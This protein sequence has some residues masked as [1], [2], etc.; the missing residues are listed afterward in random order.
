MSQNNIKI[1]L[2]TLVLSVVMGCHSSRIHM[3]DIDGHRKTVSE[4]YLYSGSVGEK[5]NSRY[6]ATNHRQSTVST[7]S[8]D[9]DTASYTYIQQCID[10]GKVPSS[11]RIRI[12]EMI[13]YFDYNY[14]SPD[15]EV[16]VSVEM[17]LTDCPWDDNKNLVH[18]GLRARDIKEERKPA[19][20]VFLIDV[21]GSMSSREKLPLLKEGMLAMVDELNRH[22][23]VAIVTYAGGAEL[24]LKSTVCSYSG[25][26]RIMEAIEDLSSGGSTNGEAG[27]HLAYEI[28]DQ[29]FQ[30]EAINRV[31]LASDGDFNV[32]ATSDNK[33]VRLVRQKAQEGVNLTVLGFGNGGFND[34]MMEKISNNGNGNYFYISNRKNAEEILCKKLTSTLQNAAEDVKLQVEFN[35][36]NIEYY[37][38]VGYSNRIMKNSDFDKDRKDAGDM[39]L[40]HTVTALYEVK[41]RNPVRKLKYE[42]T[43]TASRDVSKELLTLSIRYKQPGEERSELLR[44]TLD[45]GELT[46]D[47]DA[48]FATIVA[49]FG[50]I[51][52]GRGDINETEN[53]IE[54]VESYE[55]DD[56]KKKRDFL[57]MMCQYVDILEER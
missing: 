54:T 14:K 37:R 44:Q 25:K 42:S 20:L 21:S 9:V 18:I 31:I 57:E 6:R 24:E 41:L 53:L 51:L 1:T 33:M 15:D 52:Q 48:H 34:S 12:E 13:N 47:K 4:A 45:G 39:G 38:L 16:P 50:L 7:F 36:Q 26:K 43:P 10:D 22:D 3:Y 27:I 2:I 28:A 46:N 49:A 11:H 30:E 35:P 19:N 23:R 17:N 8:I 55:L 32:G 56:D 5:V 29:N 40:G